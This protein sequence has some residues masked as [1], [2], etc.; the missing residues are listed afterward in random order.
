[1]ALHF[2]Q[3]SGIRVIPCAVSPAAATIIS[4]PLRP[5]H[6]SALFRSEANASKPC[7]RSTYDAGYWTPLRAPGTGS[8]SGGRLLGRGVHAIFLHT[9][10]D[11]HCLC[12][13]CWRPR[14]V[15]VVHVC[16]HII[17][18]ALSTYISAVSICVI[19]QQRTI[20]KL[21]LT[22]AVCTSY[23]PA[24]A[25]VLLRDRGSTYFLCPL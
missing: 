22:T 9:N 24:C 3:S 20:Y 2:R 13:Q 11:P 19:L 16:P 1:M 25:Y 17:C 7:G 12:L 18:E 23:L 21:F 4:T 14:H 10:R 15:S 5:S 8:F 6:C